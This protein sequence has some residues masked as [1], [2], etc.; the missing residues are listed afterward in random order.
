MKKANYSLAKEKAAIVLL[1][2]S[3]IAPPILA[4][5]LCENYNIKIKLAIFNEDNISGMMNFKTNTIYVNTDESPKIIN[6]TI[7]HELGHY[8]LHKD[9]YLANSDKYE[10]LY[11]KPIDSQENTYM[12][13]EANTFAAHL[14]VPKKVLDKYHEIA[15]IESLSNL[16]AVSE[17]VIRYRLR[18]EYGY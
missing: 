8:F 10:V 13:T 16:F 14:L 6:F 15:S 17:D 1:E 12:E 2:N 9:F 18:F 11:R 7:A 4:Y 5:K 3:I